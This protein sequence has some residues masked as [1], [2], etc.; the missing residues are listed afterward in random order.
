MRK[1]ISI[2]EKFKQDCD[3][4]IENSYKDTIKR[5]NQRMAVALLGI[6]VDDVTEE[7]EQSAYDMMKSLMKLRILQGMKKGRRS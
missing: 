1:I 2:K 3:D 7:S 4:I 6:D 5:E